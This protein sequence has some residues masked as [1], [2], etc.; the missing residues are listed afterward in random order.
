MFQQCGICNVYLYFARSRQKH[1]AVRTQACPGMKRYSRKSYDP[2]IPCK[3]RRSAETTMGSILSFIEKMLF[4]KV[5]GYKT[6]VIYIKDIKFLDCSFTDTKERVAEGSPQEWGE[7]ESR[8]QGADIPKQRMREWVQEG[9]T[10][11]I[12]QRPGAI[13]QTDRY[14][15]TFKSH[16]WV[17]PS[18]LTHGN[19]ETTE[20]D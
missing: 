19:L 2:V 17:V 20:T 8:N 16:R 12:C 1:R 4:L 10:Q 13:L 9:K 11:A 14:A 7:D 6:K 3:S 18:T 15:K 5:N